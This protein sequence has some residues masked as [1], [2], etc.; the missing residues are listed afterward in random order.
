MSK[1]DEIN[2]NSS[3]NSAEDRSRKRQVVADTE[4]IAPGQRRKATRAT[5]SFEYQKKKTTGLVET[6]TASGTVGLFPDES[7]SAARKSATEE[8]VKRDGSRLKITGNGKKS[9]APKT[10]RIS[11]RTDTVRNKLKEQA[12]KGAMLTDAVREKLAPDKMKSSLKSGA[13]KSIR[14][15][16]RTKEKLS[17]LS[18]GLKGKDTASAAAS[19]QTEGNNRPPAAS[20][21]KA[22]KKPSAAPKSRSGGDGNGPAV[23]TRKKARKPKIRI[24]KKRNKLWAFVRAFLIIA[25]TC[26][27]LGI[28]AGGA[29]TAYVISHAETIHPDR[30][31]ETL[32]VSSH[33]YDDKG[34]L[35]DEIY[36]SENRQIIQYEQL[37]DNLKNAFIAIED[38]TFWKHHGF[39]VRR[40]FGAVL[41]RLK[42]GRIS[43]TSTITQQLARNVFLPEDKSVRSLK[44]K[45]TEMYYAY[46]I[47]QELSKEEILTAYLNTIYL[48]YGCYGVDTA[49]RTYFSRDVKDLNLVQCAALAA[50]PQAPHEY[51]LL[52]TEKGDNTKKIRKGLFANDTEKDRR[53]LVLQL[54]EEQGYI[55]AKQHKKAT[56]DLIDFI[57]PGHSSLASK[58]A[59][60]DYL[61]ET[62]KK[63][64]MKEYDLTEDQAFKMIYT[65]GLRI[66]STLA[67]KTQNIIQNEFK[68]NENFPKAVDGSRVQASMVIT[69]VGT[70]KIK[71]MVGGRD[72]SGEMLFNRATNPRQPGSSIKP[73]AVYAPAL[74]KSFE[75]AKAG[76]KYQ[77]RDTGYDKQGTKNW[78]KYITVSSEVT[79]EKMKVNGAD[80]PNNVTR[81]FSGHNTFRTAIQKSI[82]TCAVK[83]LA[84][85]GIEYSMDMVKKFGITTAEDDTSQSSND[86]NYAALG[87]GA[88]TEG[89]TP[90]DMALAYAAF[91]NGG[92][93]NKPIC[94][95]RVED[96]NGN[97]LLK[98]KVKKKRVLDEGVA[99]IMTDVLRSVVSHGIAGNAAVSGVRVG[100]KTGTTDD[101]YDIWF[102]GFTPEL[103]AALWIGTDTNVRMDSA[104]D[105][106]ASLWSKIMSQLSR[107]RAG[108]YRGMPHNITVRNGEFYTDGT[109][110]P[111]IVEKKDK[112]AKKDG[113]NKDGEEAETEDDE[114]DE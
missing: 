50:L 72:T 88:M 98:S 82:N 62:V 42:G 68:K 102:D 37:P 30:I 106:A 12:A 4:N 16:G 109:E 20:Q 80:W 44:R 33:I 19:S 100:G 57:K 92:V 32:D 5:V 93:V 34:D 54:M 31:Y 69:E 73:I 52:K 47:E 91:P 81:S 51:A 101:R 79:D 90:L 41:G 112:K 110:P 66:Y 96:S 55:T 71:A 27:I 26:G 86:Y 89:V 108:S 2:I 87:L 85:V 67:V 46:E 18:S 56:K 74:Q 40:L 23:R 59:F 104:S 95:T 39:N 61:I 14:L 65:K 48:G 60:K 103:S 113:K 10:F 107:S 21:P 38:K 63:D 25:V 111:V 11:G 76:M 75:Y 6:R 9:K 58:S 36:Y 8:A 64:L 53:N 43:G 114:A 17:S 45:I 15:A 1:P 28:L 84:Q 24:R 78:G 94:Y 35:I 29:Y 77:F 70:G 7:L 105:V 99:W 13:E 3:N 49:A 97:V 83:I 22:S